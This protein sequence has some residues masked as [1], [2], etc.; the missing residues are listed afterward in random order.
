MQIHD[1]PAHV[2]ASAPAAWQR[3]APLGLGVVAAVAVLGIGGLG[4]L[5]AGVALVLLAAGFALTRSLTQWQ[6]GLRAEV[7]AHLEGERQLGETL[8]PV[9]SGHI[10][11]SRTQVETAISALAERFAGIVQQLDE[12]ARLSD[13]A[14]DSIASGDGGLVAVFAQGERDLGQVVRSLEVAMGA[15]AEM[16]GK[17]Q[18]L[19]QYIDELQGMAADVARIAQ[20]TN[21]LALNAAIEAARA[22]EQGRSFAV[23]AQEVRQLSQASA[24]TGRHIAAKVTT[25]SEAITATSKAAVQ[26]RVQDDAATKQ[27][28]E[29]I[30]GVL[31]QFRRS[32]D[33]LVESGSHLKS[34]RDYL[35]QEIS[36]ALV[37]LQFQDRISQ[38]MSHVRDSID[39]VPAALHELLQ[40]YE[41]SGRL[42]ALDARALLTAL[43][44][45]YAMADERKI[46]RGQGAAGAPA[47]AAADE[48]TFF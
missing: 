43:E 5:P 12:T 22:G 42:R 9:W 26:S 6:A 31:Q 25:I 36:E 38:V 11:S 34:G 1:S 16:L 44:K 48:I 10:E 32:T 19:E 45:T 8:L 2:M 27:S 17:I 23:V 47:P 20:Q 40:D 4:L 7:Q 29:I 24:E 3:W 33:A 28:A 37:H 35:Q 15:K 14:A 39:A 41:S 21:L 18:A 46:H 30:D 13:M